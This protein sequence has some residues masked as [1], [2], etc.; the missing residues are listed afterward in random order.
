MRRLAWDCDTEDV[1]PPGGTCV[2]LLWGSKKPAGGIDG[3]LHTLL[4][5]PGSAISR[6]GLDERP[7]PH[8]NSFL[9]CTN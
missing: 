8:G 2:K 1:T 5:S 9:P 3:E 7:K 4:A 6:P